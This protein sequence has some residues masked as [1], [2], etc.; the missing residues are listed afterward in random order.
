MAVGKAPQARQE[1]GHALIAALVGMGF[2]EANT[3][4]GDE[5]GEERTHH[6]R[7]PGVGVAGGQ[8]G[9]DLARLQ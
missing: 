7:H 9:H 1:P 2:L 4:L 3:D 5:Y 6:R 8:L